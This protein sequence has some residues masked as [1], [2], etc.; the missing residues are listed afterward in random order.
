[1]KPIGTE[2]ENAQSHERLIPLKRAALSHRLF[3][4]HTPPLAPTSS[5]PTFSH[6]SVN[7]LF[8]GTYWGWMMVSLAYI[9]GTSGIS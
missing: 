1:M 3:I 4:L 5:F 7:P 9:Y 8:R 2:G 6:Q